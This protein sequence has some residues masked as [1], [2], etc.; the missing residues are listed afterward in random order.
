MKK[1][2]TLEAALVAAGSVLATGAWSQESLP[3]TRV[4]L[5]RSGVGYVERTGTVEGNVTLTLR[6]RDSQM[7]D[8]LKSMVLIDLDGG[9]VQPVQYAPRDPLSRTLSSYAIDI[10][11]NPS[12]A[13]LL[14][15]LRGIPVEVQTSDAALR[16]HVLSVETR[17]VRPVPSLDPQPTGSEKG[18]R[19]EE[20][21]FLNLLTEQG[22][23]A[24][25]LDSVKS[26]RLLDE[27]LQN[28]LT[29]A[30]QT[31][32]GGLDNVR[33][34]VQLRF[35]GS[36][37]RRV[38][39][40]YL[41]EMPVWKMTYRLVLPERGKPLLQGWAIVENTTDEDWRNV[42][43]SLV[44]GRPISFIQNLYE[45]FYR[46]RPVIRPTAEEE[47][48]PFIPEAAQAA[49]PPPHA[50]APEM[51][52]ER[53]KP[54]AAA[55]MPLP[56]SI[57]ADVAFAEGMRRSVEEMAV[58]Q[59]RGALFEYRVQVPVSIDRQ[60]SA[61]LPVV[62]QTVEAEP[63][64][65]YNPAR[66]AAHPFFGV[67]LTNTTD[68]T[69]MEGPVT[70]YYGDSY[71]GDALMDTVEPKGERIL[72]Y[73]LDWGVEV[74][75]ELQDSPAQILTLRIHRGVLQRQ[76]RQRRTNRYT[77]TNRDRRTRGVLVEQPH[78]G[79]WELIEP[80]PAERTRSFHRFRVSVE[81]GQTATLQ[82]VEERTVE[83]HYALLDED[84]D[85]L[86]ILLRSA[87]ANEAVRQAL[88]TILQR[89]NQ[90]DELRDSIKVQQ[91]RIRAIER[92]QER[93]RANMKELD[94]A[95]D[96]YKQYV[97]K[98]TQQERE[99]EEARRAVDTL[100]KQLQSAERALSEFIQNL[101]I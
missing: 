89:R 100:K 29:G 56:R 81:S 4:V 20:E 12:R 25:S 60:Q 96:L 36:G 23:Q 8:L 66:H 61:M 35:E 38:R 18:P 41:M 78:E 76:I 88:Q 65:L 59:E 10:A 57:V 3:I 43:V 58:G 83:E 54:E 94:R 50:Q 92:D 33:K 24:V 99:I 70:V 79:D 28:E 1:R 48:Q 17:T 80:K 11:D 26:I 53:V 86:Q 22:I 95:S 44:S 13:Q 101:T 62:N 2:K 69:L 30:L 47:L 51:K 74:R 7:N 27:R 64:A 5:F 67:R 9:R 91:E 97:E 82:V 16:G 46:R 55:K 98:L 14:A 68:L 49:P 63:I 75:R 52:I 32:A 15:R 84:I 45:P 34:A 71:G 42:Q 39:V 6:L 73:A 93:I 77:L 72:T 90:I 87:Q 40:G 21:S 85:T 37:R 19:G 31:L